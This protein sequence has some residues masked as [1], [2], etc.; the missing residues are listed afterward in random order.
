MAPG[1][2]K[3]RTVIALCDLLMRCNWVKRVLF[4]A[5]RPALVNQAV[6]AFKA[7]LPDSSPVDLDTDRNA[8]GR[9]FVS[10]YP[11]M[12]GL[13]DASTDGLKR[14]GVGHFDLIVIDE[15]HRSVYQKYGAI[16]NHFDSLLVG[17][18][19][20]PKGEID[21][22][23]SRFFNLVN[24]ALT[25]AYSLEEAVKGGF[26]V[27]FTAVS[28]P[29]ELPARAPLTTSEPRTRGPSG[30]RAPGTKRAIRRTPKAPRRSASGSSTLA[31]WTRCWRT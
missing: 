27:P 20:T 30:T 15:A 31:P 6:N 4:L 16:F 26:L 12:M 2:G 17:L 8:D 13:I 1:A 11:T 29:V 5:D 14:F 24:G 19:A 7:Y 10:T 18:T 3:T 22:N 25:D 28:V 21:S 23:T 9:V